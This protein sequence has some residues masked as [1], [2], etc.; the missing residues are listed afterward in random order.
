M[1][2]ERWNEGSDL[3]ALIVHATNARKCSGRIAFK[4]G[5][6]LQMV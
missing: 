1:I 4:E 2:L 3:C 6:A 5:G